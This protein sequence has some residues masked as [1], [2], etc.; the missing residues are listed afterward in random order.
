MKKVG[1]VPMTYQELAAARGITLVSA[2]RMVL[3]YGWHKILSND[4]R[5]RV[6]VPEEAIPP[7]PPEPAEGSAKVA[8]NQQKTI[9]WLR[10]S[11][12]EAENKANREAMRADLANRRADRAEAR[13]ATLE[14]E[15]DALQR[16][17]IEKYNKL[18]A[19]YEASHVELLD[20]MRRTADAVAR[21]EELQRAPW[22]KKLKGSPA[23][24]AKTA[25]GDF[26][27]TA[28]PEP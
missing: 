25:N 2:R 18:V 23:T 17:Y 11:L 3:R 26:P 4:G 1:D 5:T 7:E 21:S 15:K 6:W 10:E 8:E 16:D 19:H 9:H 22:W 27:N 20:L 12:R 24:G 14:R 13:A 28:H